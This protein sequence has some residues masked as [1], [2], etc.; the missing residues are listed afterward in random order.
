MGQLTAAFNLG[1]S[2][3]AGAHPSML[4]RG[5]LPGKSVRGQNHRAPSVLEVPQDFHRVVSSLRSQCVDAGGL[6]G[7][8]KLLVKRGKGKTPA[9]CELKIGRVIEGESVAIG[10]MQGL[11]PCLAVGVLI[12]GNVEKRQLGKGG[13]AELRIPCG[14]GERPQSGCW[15]PRG[16]KGR[17]QPHRRRR[18][19]QT[20]L[21]SH[22]S[23]LHRKFMQAWPSDQGRG[24]P[25]SFIA[26]GFPFG[27][28][29]VTE[30]QLLGTVT[31][32]LDRGAEFFPVDMP[33]RGNDARD[34]LAV[35]GDDQFLTVLD[36]IEQLAKLIFCLEG[37]EGF[38][39][40]PHD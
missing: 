14:S 22:M 38:H 30:F 26:I 29:E 24:S 39:S 20:P 9:L 10:Q 37:A 1:L 23:F 32:A 33:I 36:D 3:F 17:A 35:T 19:G 2:G 25:A 18:P 13:T 28:V 27:P 8:A 15:P 34:F 5:T 12:C 7:S 16:A 6:C 40:E 21:E 4:P 31:D 11:G